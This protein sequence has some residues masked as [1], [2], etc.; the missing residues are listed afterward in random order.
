MP[1]L[2]FGTGQIVKLAAALLQGDGNL[3]DRMVE[4]KLE[5][6]GEEV[7]EELIGGPLATAQRITEAIDTGGGSEF[8]RLRNEA[9]NSVRP[10]PLPY[11]SLIKKLQGL[12]ENN[13]AA[14]QQGSGPRGK[15]THADWAKSRQD[16]LDNRWRHDWRS[17]PRNTQ[18]RWIPGRLSYVDARLQYKG[19][20]AGRTVRTFRKKRRAKRAAARRLARRMM[21]SDNGD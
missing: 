13:K 14:A 18:G 19:V 2:G 9:L 21:G 3:I 8:E 5:H 16:W 4:Q 7:L 15:W 20:K 12:L 6:L 17:Q 1:I 10:G 11:S